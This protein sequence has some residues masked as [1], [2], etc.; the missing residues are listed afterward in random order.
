MLNMHKQFEHKH[1]VGTSE[2]ATDLVVELGFSPSSIEVHNVTDQITYY[3]KTG[4]AVE[5]I[6]GSTGVRSASAGSLALYT[7]GVS[8]GYKA[9][10]TPTYEDSSAT[11]IKDFSHIDPE[12]TK[13]LGAHLP[14]LN[15][16]N[17]LGTYDNYNKYIT[18]PGFTIK[19]SIFADADVLFITANR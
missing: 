5:K 4:M 18:K 3:F 7:G 16:T 12:G 1:T 6:T 10:E 13:V 8:I 11:E 17:E 14:K 15:T 19:A 9:G 2:G